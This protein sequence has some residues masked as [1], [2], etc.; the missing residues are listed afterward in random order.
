MGGKGKW[1]SDRSYHID[2]TIGESQT[3]TLYSH[4]WGVCYVEELYR[5]GASNLLCMFE[6]QNGR[7]TGSI[8]GHEAHDFPCL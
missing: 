2:K 3:I 1:E 7:G 5:G 4:E 6:A 8:V